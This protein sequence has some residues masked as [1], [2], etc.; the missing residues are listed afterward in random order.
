[1]YGDIVKNEGL[2]PFFLFCFV[3]HRQKGGVMKPKEAVVLHR[4]L[5]FMIFSCVILFGFT[6]IIGCGGGGGGGSA[7]PAITYTGLTTQA[8]ITD[9]NSVVL[10]SGAF[11]AGRTGSAFSGTGAVEKSSDGNIESFRTFRIAQALKD[12]ALQAD[13]SSIPGPPYIGATSSGTDTGTC[14]GTVSYTLQYNDAT[15]AFSGS[16]TFSSYC[17][18]GVT[19]SGRTTVSG[20]I[21]TGTSTLEDI[22]FD[23]TNISDGSSTLNGYIDID[24]TVSPIQIGF[25]FLLK[26]TASSKVYRVA[27]FVMEVTISAS[28]VDVNI[29]SGAYYDPDYGYVTITTP[30]PFRVYN[31]DTWP[32]TGVIVV[33]GT[34]NTKARLTTIDNTQCQIDAD[35]DGNDIYEWGPNTYN[36]ADL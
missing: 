24:F 11:G 29:T 36:W 9:T 7:P 23:F 17:D 10:S 3:N 13:L 32:S 12:A 34:G 5:Q 28:Y 14:G 4:V 6:G 26:D 30:T 2:A 15:G 1:M 18:T 27:N 22:R 20:T 16:F 25:D 35:L 8:Q 21:N 19:I 31:T 33:T